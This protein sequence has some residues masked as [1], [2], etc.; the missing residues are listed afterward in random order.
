MA[1]I[2]DLS[3]IRLALKVQAG[4]GVPAAGA[5]GT[6]IEVLPS[7]GLAAQIA[8][9]ESGMIRRSRM[10]KRPRHG[11]RTVGASY[12]TELAVGVLDKVMEAVLGGTWVAAQAF[13]NADWG[14]V[15][16]SDAGETATFAAGTLLT[17]G[18][19]AGM[20]IK[21]TNLSV[22]GNNAVYVPIIQV[23]SETV[24][25]L[26]PGYIINNVDDAAYNVAIARYLKT[27][28]PYVDRYFT[29]EENLP[30]TDMSK[31]ATDARFNALNISIDANGYVKIGFGLG[32]RDMSMET[33]GAAPVLTDPT[34]VESESLIPLDG[35]IFV[36]GVKRLDLTGIKFGLSAP[37]SGVA[38]IGTNISPD[39]FLGQFAFT[40][41]ISGVVADDTDFAAFDA[42]D[43]I[44]VI[45]HCREKETQ[46]F[47]TFYI[48]N[49][50]FAGY[51]TPAGGEGALIQS[52]PLYGGEDS[53]GAGY[54]ATTMLVSTSAA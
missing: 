19:V 27:A 15:V 11:A 6:G 23:V 5:G 4:L 49:L 36:N 52:I 38:V 14:N 37:V 45:L 44:S 32:A 24:L 46:N 34:F 41:D 16:I 18:I 54:A 51:S 20:M 10:R 29:V 47:V 40:G 8:S 42:E 9:I 53:R 1:D 13:S 7:S 50:S 21:F 30:D 39:I 31:L 25:K 17:D 33:G 48:G 28:T 3:T 43:D 2:Q 22:V 12:E 35:G 26:A